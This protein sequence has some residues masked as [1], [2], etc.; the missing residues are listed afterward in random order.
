M[1]TPKGDASGA[2]PV[3]G[4]TVS[5]DEGRRLRRGKDYWYLGRAYTRAL[6]EAGAEPI[7]LCPDTSVATAAALCD[8]IVLSGGGDL[9]PSFGE[10]WGSPSR[11]AESSVRIAWERRLLDALVGTDKP[12][13]GICFGMQLMNLHFGGT[14]RDCPGVEG[15]S[16]IDHGS[17]GAPTRHVVSATTESQLLAG[18]R[19]GEVSSAH[20]QAVDRV[21]PGFQVCAR[22]P[23]GVVEGIERWPLTGLEWHPESDESGSELYARFV[24]MARR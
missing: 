15:P 11:F 23:D 7:L 4:V 14:L 19:W 9:P 3:I 8:G 1:D 13:L 6:R 20:R 16:G 12:V 5:I 10:P 17:D 24:R 21:A 2:A 18:W 22:S